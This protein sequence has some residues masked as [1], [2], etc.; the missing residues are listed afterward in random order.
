M[1]NI[2]DNLQ[3]KEDL[4]YDQVY[5]KLMDLGISKDDDNK[6]YKV[7]DKG[8]THQV[9]TKECS[10]CKKQ[11]PKSKAIGHTWNECNKLK[12]NSLK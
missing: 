1:E 3:T 5:Q 6:A 10:Y 9:G 8:Q 2:V 4:T 11:Y 7:T 12:A